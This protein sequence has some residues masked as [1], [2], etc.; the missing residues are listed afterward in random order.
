MCS[1]NSTSLKFPKQIQRIKDK[2]SE[3]KKR[4]SNRKNDPLFRFSLYRIFFARPN[5]RPTCRDAIKIPIP[6]IKVVG[7][8]SP[9]NQTL[10]LFTLLQINLEVVRYGSNINFGDAVEVSVSN[11]EINFSQ[12]NSGLGVCKVCQVID[13]IVKKLSKFILYF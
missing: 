3:I 10:I 12:I 4:Q 8:Q 11:L 2:S 1:Q 5:I 13:E 6:P 9:T 7:L